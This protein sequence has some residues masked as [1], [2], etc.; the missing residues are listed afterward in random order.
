MN[1]QSFVVLGKLTTHC[2]NTR[3]ISKYDDIVYQQMKHLLNSL[4]SFVVLCTISCGHKVDT[5]G[6][7]SIYTKIDDPSLYTLTI[8]GDN[9]RYSYRSDISLDLKTLINYSA[10]LVDKNGAYGKYEMDGGC[11]IIPIEEADI[12]TFQVID[13]S[14]YAR[15]RNHVYFSRNGIVDNADPNSFEVINGRG[16]DKSNFYYWGEIDSSETS[17]NPMK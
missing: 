11:R 3:V 5:Y 1:K 17:D 15:D 10:F 16:K 9:E 8:E 7:Y 2:V 13:N 6:V 4:F 14:M 12:P